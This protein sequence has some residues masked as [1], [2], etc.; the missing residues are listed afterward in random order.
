[1]TLV[2]FGE[3]PR[4]QGRKL[5]PAE[6]AAHE[7]AGLKCA[8]AGADNLAKAPS[9]H[10]FARL[11]LRTIGSPS[12][13]GPARRVEREQRGLYENFAL[14][15]LPNRAFAEFKMLGSHLA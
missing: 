15:G 13:P 4:G 5:L 10:Y 6:I 2:L 1:M 7:I 14:A 11:E 9:G 3:L 8:R 12:H